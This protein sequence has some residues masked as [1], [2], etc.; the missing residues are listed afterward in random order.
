MLFCR[1]LAVYV[2]EN[3]VD[4]LLN[5]FFAAA[6]FIIDQYIAQPRLQTLHRE[7]GVLKALRNQVSIVDACR[8]G[9]E[10]IIKVCKTWSV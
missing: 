1:I 6:V 9:E 5:F 8:R 7:D 3:G 2:V 10:M 4:D